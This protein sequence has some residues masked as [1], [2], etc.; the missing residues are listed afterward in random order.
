VTCTKSLHLPGGLSPG[1]EVCCKQPTSHDQAALSE[2][3]GLFALTHG[4]SI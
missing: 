4:L 2:G 3:K 1:R